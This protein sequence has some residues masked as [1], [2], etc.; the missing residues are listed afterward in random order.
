MRKPGR[1]H[2]PCVDTFLNAVRPVTARTAATPVYN[3]TGKVVIPSLKLELA[4]NLAGFISDE[5][6]ISVLQL[7]SRV[8]RGIHARERI[9]RDGDPGCRHPLLYSG[10][11]RCVMNIVTCRST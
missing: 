4:L 6:S 11:V 7:P 9:L 1:G 2:T 5:I 3:F 8:V 10:D